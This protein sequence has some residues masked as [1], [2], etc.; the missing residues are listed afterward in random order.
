[1]RIPTC[2]ADPSLRKLVPVVLQTR[3][4]RLKEGGAAG[5]QVALTWEDVEPHVS[6]P[7]LGVDQEVVVAGRGVFWP[8]LRH[9]NQVIPVIG[10]QL[11]RDT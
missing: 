2:W 9:R 8:K 6:P 7:L 11:A 5:G 1:M 3:Q 10:V 4:S